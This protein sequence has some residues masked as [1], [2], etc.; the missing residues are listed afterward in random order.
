M[1]KG[2]MLSHDNYTW[3]CQM[4]VR[5][6][7]EDIGDNWILVSYLPLSHVAAQIIDVVGSI[8]VGAHMYFA[9]PS[10]L[11]GSLVDTLKEIRPTFFFSVPRVWEKIEEKM[12]AIAAENG[13]LKTKLGINEGLKGWINK[14]THSLYH[15]A[16]GLR[17]LVSKE[18]LLRFIRSTKTF[19]LVSILRR[20]QCSTMSRRLQVSIELNT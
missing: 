16:T 6:Y 11:S 19:R 18:L 5:R 2:V 3:T 20:R 13:Y 15:Q 9:E 7:N 1:P 17:A 8:D 12:K 4:S 10:A 14:K